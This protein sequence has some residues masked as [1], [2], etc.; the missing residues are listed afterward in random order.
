M[1]RTSNITLI[2]SYAHIHLFLSVLF[3]LVQGLN[4]QHPQI[5]SEKVYFGTQFIDLSVRSPVVPRQ[6]SMADGHSRGI[7]AY[8]MGSRRQ[9][10]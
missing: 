9:R 2:H 5:K 1:L 3:F 8:F 7:V 6:D 4:T 10:E